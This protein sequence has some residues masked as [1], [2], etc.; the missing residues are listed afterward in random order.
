MPIDMERWG[1]GESIIYD[2]DSYICVT[3]QGWVM[4]RMSRATSVAPFTNMV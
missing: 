4:Y 3:K 1:L 2:N